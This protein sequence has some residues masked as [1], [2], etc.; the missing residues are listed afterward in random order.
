MWNCRTQQVPPGEAAANIV[1][2]SA[3]E[4]PGVPAVANTASHLPPLPGKHAEIGRDPEH[5]RLGA[6]SILA[7]L[8]LQ[9][10]HITA[11]VEDSHRSVDF[12]ALLS[13]IDARYPLN[14][15]SES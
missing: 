11:R 14:A 5:K 10:G 1:A 3:N 8:D 6:C 4:K 9:D 2:L 13:E 15:R 7:A 12:I